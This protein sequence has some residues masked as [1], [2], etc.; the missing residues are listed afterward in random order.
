MSVRAGFAPAFVLRLDSPLAYN[1]TMDSVTP[2]AT[3]LKWRITIFILSSLSGWSCGKKNTGC[4]LYPQS[5][6]H[7][8]ADSIYTIVFYSHVTL[9]MCDPKQDGATEQKTRL[10]LSDIETGPIWYLA[11]SFHAEA[12][13]FAH[14]I[15]TVAG[16]WGNRG[17]RGHVLIFFLW[18]CFSDLKCSHTL[19]KKVHVVGFDSWFQ[20]FITEYIWIYH[21]QIKGV[22]PDTSPRYL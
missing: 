8:L 22:F 4:K 6:K 11:E 15:Q 18:F 13:C 2:N 14:H 16:V 17:H 21:W 3:C 12:A 7:R 10:R 20:P 9:K 19:F 5:R 1:E